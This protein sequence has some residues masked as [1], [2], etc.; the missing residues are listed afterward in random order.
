MTYKPPRIVDSAGDVCDDHFYYVEVH[1]YEDAQ[2]D[3]FCRMQAGHWM[4]TLGFGVIAR[5]IRRQRHQE[6]NLEWRVRCHPL[7][8]RSWP[9]SVDEGKFPWP[10]V[11]HRYAFMMI[12]HGVSQRMLYGDS[13]TNVHDFLPDELATL[14]SKWHPP[15]DVKE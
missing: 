12:R 9:C 8:Q 15:H 11:G 6:H 5:E 14:E 1:V 10:S 13:L 2:L 3:A 7:T 4:R